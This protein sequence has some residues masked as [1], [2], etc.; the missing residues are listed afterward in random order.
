V[1]IA[2]PSHNRPELLQ[3][4]LDRLNDY[5]FSEKPYVFLSD[6]KQLEI[7]NNV[8]CEK[9]VTNTKGIQAK[10]N[11]IY[12]YFN[13]GDYIVCFDD[14]YT[15]IKIK[16]SNKLKPFRNVKEL[17]KIG[18]QEMRK[19]NTCMYGINISENPFF[20]KNVIQFGNYAICAKF[21]GFIK[22]QMPFFNSINSTGLCE[23]QEASMRVTAKFGGVIRFSGLT[24]DKPKYGK[25]QGGLQSHYTQ[26]ERK[27]LEKKGNIILSKMFPKLCSL[28]ET[29]IGLRYKRI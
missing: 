19:N 3:K 5:G 29:G 24:F 8:N 28:K 25:L 7:Y 6:K 20:M 12:S 17:T 10:R 4:T 13:E 22:Q 26:K 9:I 14:S 2:I 23:D 16:K 15:G 18:Y 21:H 11:F 1:K 27:D